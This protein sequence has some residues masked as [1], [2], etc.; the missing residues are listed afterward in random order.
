MSSATEIFDPYRE[1]LG[2]EPHEMPAD[3]YR[4]LGLPRFEA[5]AGKIVAAA[6]GRMA[7]IRS[8]QT[9]P[10]GAYAHT[11]LNEISAAKL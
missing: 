6:D 8:N 10:R 2:I 4:L 9:G 7:L 3:H 1:W 5:D 11:L